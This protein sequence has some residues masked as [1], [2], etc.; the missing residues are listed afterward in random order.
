[1]TN[2]LINL[3]SGQI[4]QGNINVPFQG[5]L[6]YFGENRVGKNTAVREEDFE[7]LDY[8]HSELGRLVTLLNQCI[9]FSEKE[10]NVQAGINVP[11]RTYFVGFWL[12]TG[13]VNE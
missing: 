11:A 7:T 4:K 10:E 3:T 6:R 9:V 13:E 8:I 12:P 5:Y 2:Y 1:M